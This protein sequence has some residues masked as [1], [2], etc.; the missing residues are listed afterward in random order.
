M[1]AM[2]YVWQTHSLKSVSTVYIASF[3]VAWWRHMVTQIWVNIGLGNGQ[4]HIECAW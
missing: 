4:E 3:I 1:L 2:E